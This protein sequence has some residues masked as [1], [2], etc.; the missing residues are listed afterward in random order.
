[1]AVPFP[2]TIDKRPMSAVRALTIT[3]KSQVTHRLPAGKGGSD[4]YDRRVALVRQAM[5][6]PK[7]LQGAVSH[8]QRNRCDDR[9]DRGR[10]RVAAS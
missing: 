9:E 6:R 7:I 8:L 3:I 2:N 5:G 4:A 1:M 10:G